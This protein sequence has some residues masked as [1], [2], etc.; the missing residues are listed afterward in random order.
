MGTLMQA[1][2]LYAGGRE[3]VAPL[4]LAAVRRFHQGLPALDH[5]GRH[6][7]PVPVERGAAAPQV[8][9]CRGS[10][11][12]P[13]RRGGCPRR[14]RRRAGR[15]GTRRRS[16][17]VLPAVLGRGVDSPARR[18]GYRITSAKGSH[19][20]SICGQEEDSRQ[21]IA[22]VASHSRRRVA[23]ASTERL[24]R[25]DCGRSAR[26]AG[27]STSPVSTSRSR[28]IAAS[29]TCS[30]PRSAATIAFHLSA[31]DNRDEAPATCRTR[32]PPPPAGLRADSRCQ[33]STAPMNGHYRRRA[34]R[35]CS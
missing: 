33:V 31:I 23:T 6:A 24:A 22:P 19:D 20:L 15:C 13:H 28:L 29:A 25:C 1:N 21:L 9:Q 10:G 11:R 18:T 30:F 7:R 34:R 14:L 4:C 8:A 3:P 17:G 2:L 35:S 16:A 5:L 12:T 32:L 26:H 27:R